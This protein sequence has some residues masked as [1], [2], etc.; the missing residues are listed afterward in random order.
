MVGQYGEINAV[1]Y[2]YNNQYAQK[3][4]VIFVCSNFYIHTIVVSV[5]W[6]LLS[7]CIRLITLKHVVSFREVVCSTS[8]PLI[9]NEGVQNLDV[10][11]LPA[12][13]YVFGISAN[14]VKFWCLTFFVTTAN[15]T[16]LDKA[17]GI[18][19]F[20]KWQH[21]AGDSLWIYNLEDFMGD[22]IPSFL[23]SF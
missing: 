23:R 22:F 9:D 7:V 21:V 10:E 15:W 16:N 2:T 11:G 18:S 3:L 1:F 4:I 13:L 6:C 17:Q 14:A 19:A 8:Q 12:F 20:K 5:L